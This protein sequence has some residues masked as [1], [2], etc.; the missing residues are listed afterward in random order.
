MKIII[1]L[2][3]MFLMEC[4]AAQTLPDDELDALFYSE[5]DS[6]NF[7]GTVEPE[8]F[9]GDFP[10][11]PENF[12]FKPPPYEAEPDKTHDYP[13][14]YR[15]TKSRR[16]RANGKCTMAGPPTQGVNSGFNDSEYFM[17]REDMSWKIM[18][19]NE[20]IVVPRGFVTDFASVPVALASFGIG[21]HGAYSRAATIHD[22]LYWAQICNKEQADNLMLLAMIESDVSRKNQFTMYEG[23]NWG[24]TM[25]WKT[26]KADREKGKL[27]VVPKE[28]WGDIQAN[29]TWPEVETVLETKEAKDPIFPKQANYCLLGSD[30]YIKQQRKKLNDK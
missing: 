4:L 15:G 29:Q 12:P 23:V 8:I 19:T 5:D 27:R 1:I 10:D 9:S 28:F 22:F 20:E 2:C 16:C 17:L 26:N 11:T 30:Q 14:Y 24:G 18:D 3:S 6:E 25:A 7:T 21:A 13:L